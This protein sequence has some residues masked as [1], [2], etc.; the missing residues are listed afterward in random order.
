M[1]RED[2]QTI[3]KG[4]KHIV[5]TVNEHIVWKGDKQTLLF[6]NLSI[7]NRP[8]SEA[9]MSLLS[10][11]TKSLGVSSSAGCLY[12]VTWATPSTLFPGMGRGMVACF[13]LGHMFRLQLS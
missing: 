8:V 10:L 4:D 3:C 5:C 1:C 6:E 9:N 2:K 7:Q 11:L 13:I 12:F